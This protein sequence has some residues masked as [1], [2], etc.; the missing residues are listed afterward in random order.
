M[1]QIIAYS[2]KGLPNESC[3]LLGGIIDGDAKM[4]KRVYL[5]R[6]IDKNPEHFS[7]DPAEQ[8]KAIGDMRKNGWVL[9]GNFHSHP[10]SPSRPSAEDIRFAFDANLSYAI[11]SLENIKNPVFNSFIIKDNNIL[12]EQLIILE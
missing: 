5:L 12:K 10:A 2:I 4:V 8:F 9:M 7:M 11:L 6:N 1:K 3:G